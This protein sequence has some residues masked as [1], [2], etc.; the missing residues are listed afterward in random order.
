MNSFSTIL[1][2]AILTLNLSPKQLLINLSHSS[3]TSCLGTS[4][5]LIGLKFIS[6]FLDLR[7]ETSSYSTYFLNDFL[8]NEKFDGFYHKNLF[9]HFVLIAERK[10]FTI[11]EPLS[12]LLFD[13]KYPNEMSVVIQQTDSPNYRGSTLE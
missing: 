6:K 7:S 3:R 12:A 4:N 10:A 9:L 13:F 5:L 11:Q 2:N 8:G 1:P